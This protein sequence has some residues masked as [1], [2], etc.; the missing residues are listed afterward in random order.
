MLRIY[1]RSTVAKPLVL[2]GEF[3]TN[4]T[5]IANRCFATFTQTSRAMSS[6]IS[7]GRVVKDAIQSRGNPRLCDSLSREVTRSKGGFRPSEESSLA[8]PAES[9]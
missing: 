2:L 5:C 4:A 3:S 1:F 8:Y 9:L 6:G 7:R